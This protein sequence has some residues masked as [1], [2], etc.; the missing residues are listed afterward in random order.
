MAL[1]TY[2]MTTS[3]KIKNERD[4]KINEK[5]EKEIGALKEEINNI[6]QLSLANFIKELILSTDA[7][8]IGVGAVL[9]QKE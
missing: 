3:L 6:K 5:I 1:K 8:N 2:N 7:S 4:W 9:Y